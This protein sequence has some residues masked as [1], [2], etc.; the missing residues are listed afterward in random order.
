MPDGLH[1][2]AEACLMDHSGSS[3]RCRKCHVSRKWTG[4]HC[5]QSQYIPNTLLLTHAPGR[6]VI[7][8]DWWKGFSSAKEFSLI[9]QVMGS[10]GDFRKIMK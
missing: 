1:G 8:R 9:K 4:S 7:S 3:H 5:I 2:K 6:A 10:L